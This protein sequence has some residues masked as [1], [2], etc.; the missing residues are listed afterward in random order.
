MIVVICLLVITVMACCALLLY[1]V[2]KKQ[3]VGKHFRP[4]GPTD[5][6]GTLIGSLVEAVG[7]LTLPL[8]S[9]PNGQVFHGMAHRRG[10]ICFLTGM[11]RDACTCP[12]CKG[13][14]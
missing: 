9:G 4:L 13:T 5:H 8:R 3:S 2:W 12:D 6:Q 11:G 10:P 14:R 1:Q 7:T